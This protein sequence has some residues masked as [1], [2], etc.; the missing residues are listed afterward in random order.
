MA[1]WPPFEPGG[2]VAPAP[3]TA[4]RPAAAVVIAIA[5]SFFAASMQALVREVSTEVHP[6]QI[7]FV[8]AAVGALFCAALVIGMGTVTFRPQAPLLNLIR[9]VLG[10]VSISLWFLGLSLVPLAEPTA[11]SFTSVIFASVGAILVLGERMGLRRWSGVTLS[12]LGM[13]VMLRP[14]AEAV[15]VGALVV[16]GASCVGGINMLLSK[17]LVRHDPAQTVVFWTSV[18]VSV[19]TAVPAWLVWEAPSAVAWA[20]MIV[21][22]CLASLGMFGMTYAV[23]LADAT[24]VNPMEFTRLVW[25][26]ILGYLLFAEIPD[27]WTA[28]GGLMIMAGTL[29]IGL[30]EAWIARATRRRAL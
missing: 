8:R 23:R 28:T 24:L 17:V 22:G 10:G 11:L 14:G 19:A 12:V 2:P 3:P 4:D 5:G 7:A 15:Q 9:G 27:G 16:L 29:Y 13:L 1:L 25:A 26:T 21:I 30:R 20:K 18:I 6:F